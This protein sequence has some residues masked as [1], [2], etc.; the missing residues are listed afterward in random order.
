MRIRDGKNSDPGSGINIPDPQHW[1][2]LRMLHLFR[3]LKS[4][5]VF[6]FNKNIR[7]SPNGIPGNDYSYEELVKV[8]IFA[9]FFFSNLDEKVEKFLFF[10][11]K[12]TSFISSKL[13]SFDTC[14]WFFKVLLRDRVKIKLKRGYRYKL[15]NVSCVKAQTYRSIIPPPRSGT[16][17]SYFRPSSGMFLS[18]STTLTTWW[19][20]LPGWCL[21][22]K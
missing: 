4:S 19:K 2:W 6:T 16:L 8:S 20:S 17:F 9:F 18:I 7:E 13:K 15:N 14:W 1:S 21:R 12:S 22:G 5:A 10:F 11:T 3:S